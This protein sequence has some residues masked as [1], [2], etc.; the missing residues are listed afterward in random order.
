[1]RYVTVE[2]VMAINFLIIEKY[3]LG[4]MRSVKERTLLE[5]AVYRHQQSAFGQDVYP[6]IFEKT[7][8]LFESLAKNHCFHNANKRT[9]FVAFVQFLTCSP[10]SLPPL[11]NV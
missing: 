6:T 3:S 2:E 10:R 1:M 9:A 4:E 8:T 11:N 7:A 5:S